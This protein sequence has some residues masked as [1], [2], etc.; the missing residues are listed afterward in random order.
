MDPAFLIPSTLIEDEKRGQKTV[1]IK[2]WLNGRLYHKYGELL[3]GH[4]S[5][6]CDCKTFMRMYE[7][8]FQL[9]VALVSPFIIQQDT[10]MRKAIS[11][12]NRPAVTLRFLAT[13]NSFED[14][15]VSS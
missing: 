1:L 15:K 7:Q 5:E 2:T 13:G 3:Q 14:L 8:L 9:Q 4:H 11:L 12:A 6:P 10:I